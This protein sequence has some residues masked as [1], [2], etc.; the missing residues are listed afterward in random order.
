[1]VINKLA[2]I[3]LRGLMASNVIVVN[4]TLQNTAAKN[5]KDDAVSFL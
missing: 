5:S 4:T 2:I 3:V 1:M